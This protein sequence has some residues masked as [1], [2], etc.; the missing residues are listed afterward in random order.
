MREFAEALAVI[1]WGVVACV[2][3]F[4]LALHV[5]ALVGAALTVVAALATYVFQAAVYSLDRELYHERLQR[6]AMGPVL[7]G[8]LA[9]V[10]TCIGV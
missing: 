6:W 10:L 9:F 1:V 8:V 4:T 5:G 2:L 7:I 3:L